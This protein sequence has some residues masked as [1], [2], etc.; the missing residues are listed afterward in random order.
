MVLAEMGPRGSRILVRVSSASIH[1]LALYYVYSCTLY[2]LA[3][4]SECTLKKIVLL[5]FCSVTFSV[6]FRERFRDPNINFSC[7]ELTTG[8]CRK[9]DIS[10][11]N[12]DPRRRTRPA[13][14]VFDM[15]FLFCF[16]FC[17]FYPFLQPCL[18]DQAV[19]VLG[20]NCMSGVPFLT[21]KTKRRPRIK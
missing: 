8:A 18:R 20:P 16:C 12:V 5:F 14:L 19:C 6:A 7:C 10:T 21:L 11:R 4:E 17:F 1:S 15:I 9:L 3:T 2:T 13:R